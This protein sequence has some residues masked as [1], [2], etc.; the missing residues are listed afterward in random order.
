MASLFGGL[1]SLGG[2]TLGEVLVRVGIDTKQLDAGLAKAEADSTAAGSSLTKF[3]GI[4]KA[5][6]ASAG[7][8]AVAFAVQ[9]VAAAENHQKVLTTLGIA[10]ENNSKLLGL[11]TTMLEEQAKALS[12]VS[13]FTQDAILSSDQILARYRL[14]GTQLQ[15]LTAV[16]VNY[17]R[18]IGTD[19]PDAAGKLG[20]ALLGQGRA[21][22]AVGVAFKDTGTV[23]GNFDEIMT[24]LAPKVDGAAKAYGQTLPGQI[25]RAK[26]AFESLE[27]NL[28]TRLIPQLSSQ[29]EIIDSLATGH[30]PQLAASENNA[31]LGVRALNA[32]F[33][34]FNLGA[35]GVTGTIVDQQAAIKNWAS[36][37]A[38]GSITLEELKTKL[39]EAGISG[40]QLQDVIIAVGQASGHAADDAFNLAQA[41]R[42]GAAA[43]KAQAQAEK[44]LANQALPSL[45]GSILNLKDAQRALHQAQGDSSTSAADLKAK[46]LDV[47][48]AFISVKGAAGDIISQFKSGTATM[49]E[50]VDKF[51]AQA[52]AAG[53]TKAQVKDLDSVYRTYLQGLAS[54]P[55]VVTT[56]IR[57]NYTHQQLAT[58]GIALGGMTLVGERGP[59]LVNLPRGSMVHNADDT[60][61]MGGG[62][63][64]V[65][66]I[67]G[68]TIIG[69]SAEFRAAVAGAVYDAQRKRRS[70]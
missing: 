26:A 42:D 62:G 56:T 5:A 4:A 61:R 19:A 64:V 40:S 22:K 36:Q 70:A 52:H 31:A 35:V 57:T 44:E 17:A 58:G 37:V 23:A 69:N 21:L 15:Q 18:F 32:E 51:N 28:G 24:K 66:N 6:F 3:G 2:S 38:K 27:V 48:N 43:A 8:A 46:E 29:I 49:G 11:N 45:I 41:Q 50:V 30:L 9:A 13:G 53:L 10:L 39:S 60:R 47:Y 67:S 1:G 16:T 54:T 12:E 63:S 33:G 20:K 65:V 34:S 59:E 68:G 14:T 25:D 55:S 7:V